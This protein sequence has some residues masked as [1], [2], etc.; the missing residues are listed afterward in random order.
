MPWAQL[1]DG[2]YDHPKLD[3]LGTSRLAGVGLWTL[4]IAWSN[5]YLTDG[6][7]PPERVIRLGGTKKLAEALVS[8][9]L[10]EKEGESYRI[11][12]FLQYS[13]SREDVEQRRADARERMRKRREQN[14]KFGPGSPDV[15]AN[16][17]GT[18]QEVPPPPSSTSTSTSVTSQGP[19]SVGTSADGSSTRKQKPTSTASILAEMNLREPPADGARLTKAQYEA[20]KSF[21]SEWDRFKAAWLARGFKWPPAGSP[22]DDP[23]AANPSQR[24]LLYSILDSRPTDLPRWVREAPGKQPASVIGFVLQSWHAIRETVPAD[25]TH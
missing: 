6:L 16:S 25:R 7:I 24:A 1:D 20:W 15:H 13:V 12:D 21:G 5:R 17:A 11:H 18:S 23:E 19:P 2:L 3:M 22:D 10:W 4:A 9:G 14:G 8:V